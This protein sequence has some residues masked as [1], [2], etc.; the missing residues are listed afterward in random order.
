MNPEEENLRQEIEQSAFLFLRSNY[1]KMNYEDKVH[2]LNQMK[3]I[4][5]EETEK[6]KFVIA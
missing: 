3:Q 2:V 5:D 4:I 1:E 6:L